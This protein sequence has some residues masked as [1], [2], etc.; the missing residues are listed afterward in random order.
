MKYAVIFLLL[1]LLL[2]GCLEKEKVKYVCPDGN[3]VLDLENCPEMEEPAP[4]K[5][6]ILKYVCPDGEVVEEAGGCEIE[7][8]VVVTTTAPTTTLPLTTITA[9]VITTSTLVE[10]TTTTEEITTSTI[11]TTT[12]TTTTSSV[13]TTTVQETGEC[14]ELGCSA[15]TEFVGSKNSDKYHYCDC[16]YVKKIKSENLLCFDD[17]EDA[18]AEGYVP[19]GVCKPPE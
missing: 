8:K 3:V 11:I 19:C 15:G 13:T 9:L 16:R 5:I 10:I 7:E 1:L 14:A 6:T 17:K 18:Q 2:S 4:E 12:S